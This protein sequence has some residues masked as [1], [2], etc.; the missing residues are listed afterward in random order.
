[1][2]TKKGVEYRPINC[3]YDD[4][5]KILISKF[6]LRGYAILQLVLNKL[7]LE[8]GYYLKWT[9][10]IIDLFAMEIKAPANVVKQVVDYL[11]E[12]GLFDKE[13]YSK[14]SILTSEEIQQ[15]YARITYKRVNQWHTPQY[16]IESVIKM[17]QNDGRLKQNDSNLG[18]YDNKIQ[19]EKRTAKEKESDSNSKSESDSISEPT[20]AQLLSQRLNKELKNKKLQIDVNEINLDLLCS[21]VL[22]SDFLQKAPNLNVDWLIKHYNDVIGGKYKNITTTSINNNPVAIRQRTY[23]KDEL[24]NVFNKNIDDFI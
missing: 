6:G 16:V 12:R 14:F 21:A 3:Y 20:P 24:E 22:E 13:M 23:T 11:I 1:M 17:C 10:D 19:T 9:D 8:N 15:E 4:S 5:T 2:Y 7:Y 18:E